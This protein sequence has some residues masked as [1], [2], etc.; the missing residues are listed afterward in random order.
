MGH[1]IPSEYSGDDMLREGRIVRIDLVQR[2]VSLDNRL[3]LAPQ[4]GASRK[5]LRLIVCSSKKEKQTN[6]IWRESMRGVLHIQP[7]PQGQII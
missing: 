5:P 4:G 3:R 2:L 1:E 6:A 7:C